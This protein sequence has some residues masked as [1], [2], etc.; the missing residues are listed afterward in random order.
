MK[1]LLFLLLLFVF[2]GSNNGLYNYL[3]RRPVDS[4]SH[5]KCS[6]SFFGKDVG[7]ELKKTLD[8]ISILKERF[9]L[10]PFIDQSSKFYALP[11]NKDSQTDPPVWVLGKW[12]YVFVSAAK[13]QKD[14][15]L[16]TGGNLPSA[17]SE[18]LNDLLELLK[19]ANVTT[20]VLDV[21]WNAGSLYDTNGLFVKKLESLLDSNNSPKANAL[22]DA[23][24]RHDSIYALD[25]AT[26]AISVLPKEKWD[27]EVRG[28]CMIPI[29]RYSK[30]LLSPT[31]FKAKTGQVTRK[32]NLL[33]DTVESYWDRMKLTTLDLSQ[34]NHGNEMEGYPAI[35]GDTQELLSVIESCFSLQQ[36]NVLDKNILAEI[37][38][39]LEKFGY[40][41]TRIEL[42]FM[43]TAESTCQ[44]SNT[45]KL[46]CL[47]VDNSKT[48][49][50][51]NFEPT[52]VNNRILSF[53][54]VIYRTEGTKPVTE[55]CVFQSGYQHYV[56]TE[57]CCQL[58]LSVDAEAI[59]QCPNYI[60]EN[61]SGITL[62]QKLLRVDATL[63]TTITSSC[64]QIK[65]TKTILG[66]DT[67]MLSSCNLEFLSKLGRTVWNGYQN[68]I[69]EQSIGK[70]EEMI[71]T[72]DIIIYSS[73]GGMGLILLTISAGIIFYCS[74]KS[75]KVIC[76][77]FKRKENVM[78]PLSLPE[79]YPLRSYEQSNLENRPAIMY[80]H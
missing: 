1:E 68:F 12:P 57:K 80:R 63:P 11:T 15:C 34:S 26:K 2:L 77:C 38:L 6:A 19:A 36:C 29:N 9:K 37:D 27:S 35:I 75:D 69:V 60:L 51:M 7:N 13:D 76:F 33:Y 24:T 16:A 54:H 23:I 55:T 64:D 10:G 49:V 3:G 62:S 41:L 40:A 20:Q 61:Y 66:A 48:W 72:K 17:S 18:S 71:P 79:I 42:G 46:S 70:K 78:E 21:Y 5:Q 65:D 32:L 39:L 4:L 25:S 67:L 50:R 43:E 74:K 28:L 44:I 58:V 14:K 22:T 53:D 59:N 45:L 52:P 8:R 31:D 30:Y 47:C 56:L 73:L